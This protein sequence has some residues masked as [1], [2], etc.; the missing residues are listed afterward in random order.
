MS[1]SGTDI[2]EER[3]K[4]TCINSSGRLTMIFH[5]PI[6]KFL[7]PLLIL[8]ITSIMLAGCDGGPG[9]LDIDVTGDP[10]PWT[11]LN[12]YNNP[13][14][15]Q[16]AIVADRN[17]DRR[18]GIFSQAVEKLNL[19][20]PEFVMCV[21]DLI[22]GYTEEVAIL[23][24]EWDEFESRVERLQMPFFHVIGNHDVTNEFMISRW[25]ERFGRL[26]Y[27]FVYRDVLFLCL[28]SED[29]PRRAGADGIGEDQFNY[30]R[31]VLADNEGVRWTM[32]FLHK[33]MWKRGER[34]EGWQ[35]FEDLLKGRNYTAFAGHDHRYI[36]TTKDGT[37]YYQ[38]AT[39][40]GGS[41]LRGT[42]MGEFDH[43]MWV[44]MTAE[45][46]RIA[47]LLLEGILDDSAGR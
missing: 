39:T 29:P 31:Q 38:L 19:L 1:P 6:R 4:S 22:N 3:L 26:Y 18:P 15:F 41:E 35:P 37:V 12:L 46:P 20:L 23:D 36:K 11:N 47:N 21:G 8:I 40:G 33:P 30:F 14:N 25:K 27:H 16:F 44:T 5:S 42:E 9:H 43:I 24:Q 17:G 34:A 45:G 13:D 7:L 10:S 2:I 28:D 32:V